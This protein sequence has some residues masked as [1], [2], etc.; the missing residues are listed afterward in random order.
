[1][2]SGLVQRKRILLLVGLCVVLVSGFILARGSAHPKPAAQPSSSI[3][4]A[5]AKPQT[6]QAPSANTTAPSPAPTN[7]TLHDVIADDDNPL[8]ITYGVTSS[9]SPATG[10]YVAYVVATTASGP[11]N[12][13]AILH[14]DPDTNELEVVA[15]PDTSFPLSYLQSIG[16]PE[17][18]QSQVT[19]YE[20]N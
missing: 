18:V 11:T 20:D 16:V 15:G 1:M 2:W 3:S 12:Q 17:A 14:R 13:T 7:D 8:G 6:I 10:W 9:I 19:T 4:F 5:K